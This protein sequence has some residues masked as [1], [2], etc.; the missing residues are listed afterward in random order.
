MSDVLYMPRCCLIPKRVTRIES[1]LKTLCADCPSLS[2]SHDGVVYIT[3]KL[4]F[5]AD[6]AW[7]TAVDMRQKTLNDVAPIM[8][9]VDVWAMVMHSLKVEY[10]N[11][12]QLCLPLGKNLLIWSPVFLM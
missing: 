12:S 11:I 7:V 10:P 3:N 4:E 1:I 5:Q 2:L 8:S 9:L 6:E